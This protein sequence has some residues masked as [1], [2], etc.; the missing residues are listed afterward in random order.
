M[1]VIVKGQPAGD[2][3]NLKLFHGRR[4]ELSVQSACLLLGKSFRTKVLLQLHAGHRGIVTMKEMARSYFWWPGKDKQ[5]EEVAKSWASCCKVRNNPP[6]A[7]LHPWEFPQEP[8]H[9]VHIDFTGPI[10][11]KFF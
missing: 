6:L 9:R 2:N 10:E 3:S 11:D 7:S 8:W 5:I 1:D 4:L